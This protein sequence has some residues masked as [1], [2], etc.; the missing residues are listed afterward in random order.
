MQV[1]I[2]TLPI[3]FLVGSCEEGSMQR[4]Q[5]KGLVYV[6]NKER[7]YADNIRLSLYQC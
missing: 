4:V 6:D 3:N 5:Y 2:Y 7:L 1:Q